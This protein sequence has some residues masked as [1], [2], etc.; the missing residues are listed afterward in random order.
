MCVG[1]CREEDVCG[2]VQGG[3]CVCVQGGGYVWVC[4]RRRD[5]WTCA[6]RGVWGCAGKGM[7]VGMCREEDVCG[8]VQGGGCVWV[9][10]GR[11][12]CVGICEEGNVCR[13]DMF[14]CTEEF[15]K[16]DVCGVDLSCKTANFSPAPTL[17]GRGGGQ[18]QIVFML[19]HSLEFLSLQNCSY[20]W[21]VSVHVNSVLLLCMV[22]G[23]WLQ[24]KAAPSFPGSHAES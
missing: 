13:E 11:R 17:Y 7:C 21:Y 1:V 6:G 12:V 16:G 10:A 14:V 18:F 8:R 24:V 20:Y 9:Y 3:G 15:G 19:L 22:C 2:C 23:V 4:A 5:L